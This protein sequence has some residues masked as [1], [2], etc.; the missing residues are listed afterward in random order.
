M[1]DYFQAL[2]LAV[3]QGLTEFL[4]I[5]S[6]GHLILLPQLAGWPDQGLGFDVAVHVGT[7]LA[8]LI[9]FHSDVRKILTDWAGSVVGRP[10]TPHS[11]LGWAI[12]LATAIT[13]LAGALFADVVEGVL[14]APIPVAIATLGFGVVLG[15][16]DWL[17]VRRRSIAQVGWKDA[18]VL[19]CAQALA[20]IP[21]TSRSGITISA[22]L[23]MGLTREAAARFSFLMAIPVIALAGGWQARDLVEHG[24]PLRWDLLIFATAVSALVALGCIHW[25]LAFLRRHSLLPF[26]IYRVV[27]G[28]ILLLVFL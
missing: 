4:P 18:V 16:A 25:F 13:G 1:N 20:L 6:S 17:G 11:K 14:R 12:F 27:L 26:V 5:S 7:L 28:V 15:L 9:Y 19:G 2:W 22:G 23:L 21:G 8:V 10:A 3:L 24:A